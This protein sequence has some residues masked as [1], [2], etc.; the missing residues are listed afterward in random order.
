VAEV[1]VANDQRARRRFAVKVILRKRI[2][3]MRK[4]APTRRGLVKSRYGNAAF[5]FALRSRRTRSRQAHPDCQSD[6]RNGTIRWRANSI[7]GSAA[8]TLEYARQA[9]M[10][11]STFLTITIGAYSC[12]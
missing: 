8:A 7:F 3:D 11:E 2:L 4:H 9:L 6:R 10:R 1:G 12:R 5:P